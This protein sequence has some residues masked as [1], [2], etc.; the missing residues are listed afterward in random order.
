MSEEKEVTLSVNSNDK[1][2][3]TY[4][5]TVEEFL[6][7]QEVNLDD[8]ASVGVALD[9]KIYDGQKV[10]VE[11]TNNYKVLVDGQ[12]LKISMAAKNVGDV[13]NEANITLGEHDIVEPKVSAAAT[14]DLVIDIHRV[15]IEEEI[16]ETELAYSVE[17]QKDST[18]FS[19]EKMV[20][21]RGQ[22]GLQADTYLV[23]YRDGEYYS[24]ELV[25]SEVTEPV[26]EI[27]AVGTV[28]VA[29]L[30]SDDEDSEN[31][32]TASNQVAPNGMSYAKVLTC[33]ATAYHEPE[34]SLT[35]SGTLSRVGAIAV[36]PSVIPLG[37]KLY[38]EGYGYC[39]AEDTGGLIKGNRIDVY[40]DSE[41]ECINWGV[42]SVTVYILN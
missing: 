28:V 13:L 17:T 41:E 29:S 6:E 9:S 20:L 11:V 2:V 14:T 12:T 30:N 34:G 1:V 40:L 8:V 22:A 7:E 42:K 10:S 33:K 31:E 21:Q 39:V 3:R 18:M 16:R 32:S 24:E 37:T 23:T 26:T 35:K 19:G 25:N 4:T 27:V 36:D 5:N 38:V 15:T